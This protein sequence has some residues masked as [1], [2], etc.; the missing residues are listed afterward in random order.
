[1]ESS[2][3]LGFGRDICG[4]FVSATRREWLVTNG[5]G[6]YA[7]GT[8]AGVLT[9]RYH[10]LLVAS[11]HPP[12]GR[13]ATLAK[14][15]GVAAYGDDTYEFAS[16]RWHDGSASP[17]GERYLQRF[18]LEGTVPV[19][20]WAFADA[21][22]EQRIWMERGANTTYVQYSLVRAS[23][24][25]R[26]SFLALAE[27]RDFHSL[28]H[29]YD[30]RPSEGIGEG[31]R[32]V[33]FEGSAEIILRARGG[34]VTARN[35]WFYGFR[36]DLEAERGLDCEGDLLHVADVEADL[37]EG[38]SFAVVAS[39]GHADVDD[40]RALER[41]REDDGALAKHAPDGAPAWIAQ[42]AV[43]S[44]AFIVDRAQTKT[45]IAGYPWFGDWGRDT[46]I[47]LPGLTLVTGRT[48]VA[49]SLLQTFARYLDGGMLPNR[50]PEVGEIPE[51]NTADA[52]LW[53]VEALRAYHAATGD[54]SL[55]DELFP[56]LQ[57]IVRAHVEGTR[58]GIGVDPSDG[59]L[60]AGV[61]GVQLTWMDA[62]VGDWVVTPRIGKPVEINALWYNALR[63]IEA[64]A[65]TRGDA[66][67]YGRYAAQAYSSFGRFWNHERAYCFDVL[68]GPEGDDPAIRPN[69]LFAVALEHAALA[70]EHFR[71]VVDTSAR[72]LLTSNGLRSLS[73]NDPHYVGSYLGDQR[74][75]DGAYHQG[76]VWAWLLGPFVSAHLRVYNDPAAAA[77]FLEPMSCMLGDGAI[78]TLGE[79][80]DGDPPFA[81]RGCFAQAWSVAEILR[82]WDAVRRATPRA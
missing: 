76:T 1:L 21:L 82:A 16:N 74:A 45:V 13:T 75:R 32:F 81:L 49:R 26:L 4:E 58:F 63:T 54:E 73:P 69:A 5:T 72:L 10:G 66:G 30:A 25:L 29:A 15:D 20:T 80:F 56:K 47:A 37:R 43:A 12:L 64:F 61:P 79:I 31:I 59:L 57:E 46:M 6:A 28:T 65:R 7:S 39:I 50:F 71:S 62:K 34:T 55:V 40:V 24:P 19:W 70:Q 2:P 33:P 68:D 36:Y 53:Y 48:D 8:I 27:Q 35:E 14:L 17:G 42:L 77:R 67:R 22:L 11:L 44:D 41:R 78:G 38:G 51:Y 52:T 3:V 18:E 9:R 60:C 23:A